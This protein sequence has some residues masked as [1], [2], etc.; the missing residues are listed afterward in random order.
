M[1]ESL[2]LFL[3][4]I[5]LQTRLLFIFLMLLIASIATVGLNTYLQ[6]KQTTLETNE[7]RLAREGELIDYVS[8]NLKFLYVSDE[9][10]FMQQLEAEVRSQTER[11]AEEGMTSATFMIKDEQLTPFQVSSE[12][13]LSFSDSLLNELVKLDS[14]ITHKKIQGTDYT[15]VVENLADQIGGHYVLAVSTD[16]YMG[17]VNSMAQTVL[18]V[19]IATLA[20]S[21][22][23]IFLFVR[24]L[25]KPLN[26]LRNTMREARNGSLSVAEIHTSIPEITSLHKSYDAMIQQMQLMLKELNS[27]TTELE[28]TGDRLKDSSSS[29]LAASEQLIGSINIVKEGAEQT[30]NSSETSTNS[31]HEMKGK[32]D[33]LLENMDMVDQSSQLMNQSAISGEQNTTQLIDQITAFGEGFKQL[34]KTIQTVN[35]HSSSITKLV[36]LIKGIAEQTKLLA[37]NA[38]IEAARAGESGQGFAVV[39]NEVRK[40]AEQAAGATEDITHSIKEMNSITTQASSEFEEMHTNITTNLTMA[41]D[42]KLSIDGLM[43]QIDTVNQQINTMEAELQNVHNTLPELEQSSVSLA[44]VSQET[45]AS[46]EEMYATSD[47]QVRQMK[48]T[49]EIGLQLTD[50]SQSLTRLTERFKEKNA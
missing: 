43:T 33:S 27:T 18:T 2:K 10:Y 14:G 34:N 9:E 30:A 42:T 46:A 28:M 11:L 29:T 5:N 39:A 50:L 44:S 19:T 36:D 45:L 4:K 16:S 1:A 49:H 20:L 3:S 6:A 21:I 48:R 38:A 41:T 15:L 47:E 24:S 17:A 12:N 26:K 25:T 22:L 7:N 8:S 23:I 35:A 32:I 13:N 31:F 37:L 40:L